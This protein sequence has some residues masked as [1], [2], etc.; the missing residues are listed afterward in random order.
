MNGPKHNY[1]PAPVTASAVA[2][3]VHDLDLLGGRAVEVRR[4]TVEGQL[5]FLEFLRICSDSRQLQDA[6]H[7]DEFRRC[8][9]DSLLLPN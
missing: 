1:L 8:H 2:L 3:R 7:G 4:S 9:D 5:S 6:A